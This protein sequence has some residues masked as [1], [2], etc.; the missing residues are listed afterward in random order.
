MARRTATSP[1]TPESAAPKKPARGPG[2]SCYVLELSVDPGGAR[3]GD[4]Y[5]YNR[6]DHVRRVLEQEFLPEEPAAAALAGY[7]AVWYGERILLW[8]VREGRVAE[9]IDLHPFLRVSSTAVPGGAVALD[10][11]AG[12]APL[13]AAFEKG[14]GF[15]DELG[16]RFELDWERIAGRAPA[17]AGEPLRPGGSIKLKGGAAQ[18][19]SLGSHLALADELPY[20]YSD[21]E[22]GEAP[23]EDWEDPDP[24]GP[25]DASP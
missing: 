17:L 8:V 11:K 4:V 9:A 6:L 24:F 19:R 20:G 23:P 1:A 2:R 12:L 18:F 14:D 25:D 5:V 22:G 21:L 15:G 7:L 3:R 10:D 13:R 16:L